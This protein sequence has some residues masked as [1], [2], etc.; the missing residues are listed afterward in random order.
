MVEVKS[1]RAAKAAKEL[2]VGLSTLVQHLQK[3]GYEIEEKPTT[4]LTEEMYKVLL[5]DFRED[6]YSKEEAAQ[7]EFSNTRK[8]DVGIEDTSEK[9]KSQEDGGGDEVMVSSPGTAA[10]EEED[11]TDQ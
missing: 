9:K 6:L 1:K 10:G 4:K 3:K 2:N 5:K 8:E 11:K 7:V